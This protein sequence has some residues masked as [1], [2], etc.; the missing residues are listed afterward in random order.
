MVLWEWGSHQQTLLQLYISQVHS[1]QDY[2]SFVYKST[3]EVLPHSDRSYTKGRLKT[4]LRSLQNISSRKLMK[5]LY[6]SE[7]K[8]L[9]YSTAQNLNPAH[10]TQLRIVSSNLGTSS[11]LQKKKKVKIGKNLLAFGWN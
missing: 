4:S 3:L 8:N 6:K 11:V 2:C 7:V 1:Q 9:P 5:H 10:P